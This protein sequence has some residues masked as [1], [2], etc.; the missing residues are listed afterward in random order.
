MGV[1]SSRAPSRTWR[2]NSEVEDA[3]SGESV[4]GELREEKV[5]VQ[6]QSEAN[7]IY[8]KGRF[9]RPR[10]GG[11]LELDLVEAAYL[12]ETERLSMADGATAESFFARA[13][14]QKDFEVRY[15][16]YREL[17]ERGLAPQLG[18]AGDAHFLVA[19]RDGEAKKPAIRVLAMNE[20][21]SA[22]IKELL[23]FTRECLEAKTQAL[24]AVVDEESEVTSY[25][26]GVDS[27]QGGVAPSTRPRSVGTLMVDRVLVWDKADAQRLHEQEFFGKPVGGCLHLSLVEAL[28]LCRHRGFE[29]M[30][31][32]SGKAITEPAL[33]RLAKK[34]EPGIEQRREVYDDLKERQLIVKTGYKFGTHFRAYER[35]PTHTHAPFLVQCVR[36][37]DLFEWPQLSR[38][39]RLAHGVRKKLLLAISDAASPTYLSM[40]RAR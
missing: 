16:V 30:D 34:I 8:N 18:K 21:S 36:A 28:H 15:Q 3:R 19:A 1:P 37:A 32:L 10:S 25:E 13:A 35:D 26:L 5:W 12:L 17:R 40:V 23:T 20:R 29:V 27:P 33:G 39:V 2:R 11:S 9:G 22:S 7:R 38:A 24:V 4:P 6:E 14:Q 31:P